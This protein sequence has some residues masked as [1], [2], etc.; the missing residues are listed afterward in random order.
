M[1][2]HAKFQPSSFETDR[3]DSVFLILS[4]KGHSLSHICS[5]QRPIKQTGLRFTQLSQSTSLEYLIKKP[6]SKYFASQFHSWDAF[7]MP[8]NISHLNIICWDQD[9]P[10]NKTNDFSLLY[11]EIQVCLPTNPI[12]FTFICQ[13]PDVPTIISHVLYHY[14][15][16][17]RCAY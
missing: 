15:L 8:S 17:S 9:V 10:T 2:L 4:I 13:D 16:K 1:N 14:L 11:A 12:S 5:I 7:V 6:S 3:G